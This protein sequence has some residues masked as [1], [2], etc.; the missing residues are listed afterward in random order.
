MKRFLAVLAVLLL[1]TVVMAS[2][3]ERV[4]QMRYRS[5]SDAVAVV[6]PLLSADGSVL[7]QP[8]ANTLVVRDVRKVLDKVALAV[9]MWDRAPF[10]YRITVKLYLASTTPDSAGASAGSAPEFGAG[11]R[12]ALQLHLV[13]GPG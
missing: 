9:A 5:A 12:A 10:T 11:V 1:A 8:R 6:E 2:V 4:F 3:E 7:L 13:H